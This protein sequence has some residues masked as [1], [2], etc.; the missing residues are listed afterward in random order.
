MKD[1]AQAIPDADTVLAMAPE[2]LAGKLL[3]LLKERLRRDPSSRNHFHIGT[4]VG[5]AL[6]TVNPPTYGPAGELVAQAEGEALAWLQGQALIFQRPGE[7][8]PG[9]MVLSRRA[10]AMA[11]EEDFSRYR[12]GARLPRELLHPSIADSVWT[13][14]VRGEY[15]TAVFQ[16]MRQVEIAMRRATD[17]DPSV[18]AVNTARAA[19]KPEVG[20]LTDASAPPG[21]QHGMMDLFAGAMGALKNPHSH[22]WVDFDSPADAAAVVVFASQLLR[23]IDRR[24]EAMLAAR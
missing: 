11:S 21:E 13:S 15:D 19:F 14:F 5:E 22:R 1:L 20:M 4:I 6:D 17:A 24:F 18:P 7:T 9:W 8:V 2:E 3:F 10:Q 12:E 23:I 16:A